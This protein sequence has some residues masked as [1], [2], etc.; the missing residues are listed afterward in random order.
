V[1]VFFTEEALDEKLELFGLD[2]IVRAHQFVEAGY[3]LFANRRCATLFRFFWL[4]I[5]QVVVRLSTK[6][7]KATRRAP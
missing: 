1:S 6:E 2:M 4:E 5:K 7:K 3:K